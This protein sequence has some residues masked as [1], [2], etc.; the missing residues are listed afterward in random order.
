MSLSPTD[1][2]LGEQTGALF[3]PHL[4]PWPGA[5]VYDQPA[6]Q[7]R[8][9]LFCILQPCL[10]S[11]LVRTPHFCFCKPSCPLEE[12]DLL[13]SCSG[14][15]FIDLRLSRS[16]GLIRHAMEGVM[17]SSDAVLANETWGQLLE[18]LEGFPHSS[19]GTQ[20]QISLCCAGKRLSVW[21]TW[22]CGSLSG[23]GGPCRS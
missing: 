4:P 23:P 7:F 21:D 22:E 5:F 9:S 3:K 11:S 1:T 10:P 13:P 19:K 20:A 6:Q 12:A 16:Q 2:W 8:A 17:W 14:Q 15:R 18:V